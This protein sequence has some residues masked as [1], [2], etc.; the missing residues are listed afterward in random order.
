MRISRGLGLLTYALLISRRHTTLT[1]LRLAFPELSEPAR[2]ALAKDAF[3]HVGMAMGETAWTWY[4]SIDTIGPI[5]TSGT[6]Y[7]DEALLKGKGVIL[8]Q[9][10]FTVLELC[11]A[12]FGA[13]W[14]M[15][16]V[17]DPPKN[18]LFAAY[19]LYQRN[20]HMDGMIDNR[21]IRE[22]VRRLR[23]GEVV[24]YSP[25]QSVS[26]SHGG[27][28]TRYFGQPVLTT[29]G[30]ARIV[31][32]TGA[33]VIPFIPERKSNGE[34]YAFRFLPP[35][36]FDSDDLLAATQ[37]VNDLLEAQVRTQP[38]Q[39]LW[40]HKRFKPPSREHPSPYK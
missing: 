1:N 24:W 26:V 6:E 9:A 28:P 37:Q 36:E 14:P 23:A 25:D 19:L 13:R 30:S 10:H 18:P 11:A 8:L 34:G 4:R 38:E 7:V 5:E 40:A 31:R 32:M 12:I 22:M 33:T 29:S 20:R 27:I 3:R 35:V 17:Y 39:Y 21:A 15:R 16:A 2:K